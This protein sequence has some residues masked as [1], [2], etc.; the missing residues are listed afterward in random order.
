MQNFF[1]TFFCINIFIYFF[2]NRPNSVNYFRKHLLACKVDIINPRMYIRC[3][4][5]SQ[6]S[7]FNPRKTQNDLFLIAISTK[8]SSSVR[9]TKHIAYYT[10]LW[11]K[12]KICVN[13]QCMHCA[14]LNQNVLNSNVRKFLMNVWV[15]IG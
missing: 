8:A 12:K 10:R 6:K 1:T 5:G 9:R 11:R 2:C 4:C 14:P 15:Y 3:L 13:N 7:I